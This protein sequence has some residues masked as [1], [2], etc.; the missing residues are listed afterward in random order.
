MTSS[1]PWDDNAE[2]NLGKKREVVSIKAVQPR[3]ASWKKIL[4][5]EGI[6]AAVKHVGQ[7]L[8]DELPKLF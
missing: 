3:I 5:E 7:L 2:K 1:G 4:T 6:K 8:F